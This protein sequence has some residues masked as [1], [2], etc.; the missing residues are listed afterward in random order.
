M[1]RGQVFGGGEG[2]GAGLAIQMRGRL[3][4]APPLCGKMTHVCDMTHLHI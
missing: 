1:T 3:W 4:E 2:S